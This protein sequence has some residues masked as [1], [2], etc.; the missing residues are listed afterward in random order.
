MSRRSSVGIMARLRNG[1]AKKCG[2][3]PGGGR[4]CSLHL[5][6][7]KNPVPG[8]T[9]T[10]P[11]LPSVEHILNIK[12]RDHLALRTA[13]TKY[14]TLRRHLN[15]HGWTLLGHSATGSE[16]VC[17]FRLQVN[18]GSQQRRKQNVFEIWVRKLK[19]KKKTV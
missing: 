16:V 14:A 2:P 12:C 17:N 6:R 3:I 11:A 15:Q 13:I 9:T 8:G 18:A 4:D 10:S 1:R 5:P 7:K 19:R